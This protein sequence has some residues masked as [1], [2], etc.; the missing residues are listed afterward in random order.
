MTKTEMM[1]KMSR[2]IHKVGFALKKHSPEILV[3]AGV[4]GTVASTVLAC[5]ATLKVNEVL[6]QPKK[7]IEKIH[8]AM[9]TGFTEAGESYSVEDSKKDLAIVYTKTAVDLAKLYGPAIIL[10]TASIL[11]IVKSHTILNKRNAALAAANTA[12]FKAYKEY[13]SRVVE[14]F[15]KELDHELRYNIKAQEVEETVANEDGTETTV[16]KTV[17]VLDPNTLGEFTRIWYEGNP[18]FT[19]NPEANKLFLQK[20][21]AFANE[22]LKRQG[23][24]FLNDV[25][26]MLGFAK[27]K[28]GFV[29]GWIYDEKNPIGDNFVDFGLFDINSEDKIRFINGD[30]KAVLLEFN[31]DGNIIDRM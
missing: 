31:V 16:T 27:T 24:L 30:E 8:E 23:Y 12:L 4:V 15:G 19:D 29:V 21:Q 26:S 13:R 17:R 22:K 20:Q 25:L 3:A 2:G 7:D 10:E 1:N 5:K 18:G 6:E 14:R 28:T 11:A 9:E